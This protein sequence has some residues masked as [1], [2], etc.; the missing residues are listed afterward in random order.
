MLPEV[1]RPPVLGHHFAEPGRRSTVRLGTPL[2]AV[3]MRV[4]SDPRA[5]WLPARAQSV[6]KRRGIECPDQA[7]ARHEPAGRSVWCSQWRHF[8]QR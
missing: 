6:P 3:V 2:G 7:W 1:G 5:G 8:V 4:A